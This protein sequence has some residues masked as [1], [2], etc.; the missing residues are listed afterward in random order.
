[1]LI[2]V[3]EYLE[4]FASKKG[5][6]QYKYLAG[7]PINAWRKHCKKKRMKECLG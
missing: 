5:A 2:F 1:M 6:N 3:S 7:L 4:K